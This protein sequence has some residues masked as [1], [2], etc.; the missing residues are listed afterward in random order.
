MHTQTLALE[1]L[2]FG[3]FSY[4]F[5]HFPLLSAFVSPLPEHVILHVHGKLGNDVCK[6]LDLVLP[7]LQLC[8]VHF[9]N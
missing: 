5:H 9:R 7:K 2:K 3:K 8:T 1:T 4:T 6:G